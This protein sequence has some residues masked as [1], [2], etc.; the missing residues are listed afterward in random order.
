M[1]CRQCGVPAEIDFHRWG[2]PAK[3]PRVADASN[4]GCLRNAE[5]EGN[6][7]QVVISHGAF[8]Q[9]DHGGVTPCAVTSEGVDPP[10][11]VAKG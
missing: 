1:E 3:R 9:Y 7:L 6:L 4:K 10:N 2:E 8:Q 11:T 5:F